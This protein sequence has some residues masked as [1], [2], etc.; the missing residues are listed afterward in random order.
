MK[1]FAQ[2]LKKLRTDS[3]I[4]Q[5]T[6]AKALG[7]SY[8]AVSKWEGAQNYPDVALLPAIADF[9]GVSVDYLLGVE[10]KRKQGQIEEILETVKT[11]LRTGDL[12]KSAALLRAGL[13]NYPNNPSLLSE[14]CHVNFSLYCA[15]GDGALLDET[16]EKAQWILQEC[17]DDD[18]R[19]HTLELLAYSYNL[20]GKQDMALA[21][22][23][24]MPVGW[25]DIV[26][27]NIVLPMDARAKQKQ[28]CIFHAFEQMITNV[29]WLGNRCV[30]RRE[31]EKAL[32]IFKRA[33]NLIGQV[34]AENFFLLRYAQALEGI[35]A[36]Y[37]GLGRAKQ[38]LS[39]IEKT[40]TAHRKY[41][42]FLTRADTAFASPLLDAMDF[43]E[44]SIEKNAAKTDYEIWYENLRQYDCYA[45]VRKEPCFPALCRRIEKDLSAL[46]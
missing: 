9:F 4:S 7:V 21:V 46:R 43:A 2:R 5:E 34:G 15:G 22:A 3:Q 39:Y 27:S 41:L 44:I 40:R 24:R 29:F 17:R 25:R 45:S 36:A 26:L 33:K 11:N 14:L 28:R 30:G 37:A 35:S 38:A 32:E 16:V 23:E 13:K 20:L 18:I 12:E 1:F 8:Q 42:R 10:P 6:L 19:F 31:Y